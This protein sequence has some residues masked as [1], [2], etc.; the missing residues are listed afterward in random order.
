LNKY[1]DSKIEVNNANQTSIEYNKDKIAKTLGIPAVI[2]DKVLTK[3][4][5]TIDNY[6]LELENAIKN[7]DLEAIQHNA[8]KVKGS[9]MTFHLDYMVE[10]LQQ[11]EDD[12]KNKIDKDYM[13]EYELVKKEL[14]NFSN[15]MNK[16]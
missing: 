4:L 5:E 11:M 14:E 6:M 15:S 9:M 10:I 7:N 1:L 3:F 13:K 2:F 8:H 12:A 16:G